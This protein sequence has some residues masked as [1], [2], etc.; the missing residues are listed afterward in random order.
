MAKNCSTND[1]SAEKESS[2]DAFDS[3][4]E[5]EHRQTLKTFLRLTNT[6]YRVRVKLCFHKWRL[7]PISSKI[8]RPCYS[9]LVNVHD[10]DFIALTLTSSA[11]ALFILCHIMWV[12]VALY[13]KTKLFR[14]HF[15]KEFSQSLLKFVILR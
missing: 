13:F 6:F 11:C 1:A 4:D 2:D 12:V 14:F 7:E 8:S 15:L 3:S 5:S 9:Y 10:F